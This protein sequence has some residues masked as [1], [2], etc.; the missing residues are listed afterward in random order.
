[1]VWLGARDVVAHHDV[2]EADEA[3]ERLGMDRVGQQRQLV[4]NFLER[5][6]RGRPR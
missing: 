2:G 4:G 5:R 1:M 3:R 6:R